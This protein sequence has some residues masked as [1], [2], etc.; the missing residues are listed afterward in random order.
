MDGELYT[1]QMEGYKRIVLNLTIKQKGLC[2]LC[3][4]QMGKQSPIVKKHGRPSRYYH[5]P[6]AQRIHLL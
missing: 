4:Q 6:C 3:N 1:A 2:R 5:V